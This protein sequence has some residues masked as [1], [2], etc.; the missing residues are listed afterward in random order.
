[1]DN[2][3]GLLETPSLRCR[4][5]VGFSQAIRSRFFHPSDVSV[6]GVGSN[7]YMVVP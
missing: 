7:S 2:N 6:S 5:S 3:D 1:M 4:K